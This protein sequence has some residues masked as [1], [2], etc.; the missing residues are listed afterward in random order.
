ME[1]YFE[2]GLPVWVKDYALYKWLMLIL[3]VVILI[4]VSVNLHYTMQVPKDWY[5]L[6]MSQSWQPVSTFRDPMSAPGGYLG[7]SL[8]QVRTDPGFD[9]QLSLKEKQ[10]L[11]KNQFTERLIEAGRDMNVVNYPSGEDLATIMALQNSGNPAA[12]S[13]A[14]A[15][16]RDRLVGKK[17]ESH[18]NY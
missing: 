18:V 8:N 1:N 17:P 3:V 14:T 10:M 12:T 13:A 16:F 9:T 2:G 15:G 5:K 7:G 4:M 6:W 11:K